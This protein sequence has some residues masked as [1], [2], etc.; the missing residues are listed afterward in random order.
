MI[1]ILL[2]S[3]F[4]ALLV[5]LA[6]LRDPAR[7]PRLSVLVLALLA[8]YPL[9]IFL[10][11]TSVV[12]VVPA[13]AVDDS[14]F[15]WVTVVLG[16]WVVGFSLA[17][18]R[19]LVAA[20]MIASWRKRSQ[21]V[22]EVDEVEIRQLAGL[23]GPVA[24]GVLR[25]VIFVPESW[26]LWSEEARKIVLAHELAHHLRRDPLWRWIAEIA[27]AVHGCNPLVVW[28]S[29]RMSL[30]GEYACDA[31]VLKNGVRPSDY[32]RLLCEFAEQ[33]APRGPVMAMAVASTL[34]SRVKR[35]MTPPRND[36]FAAL[37]VLV[38]LTLGLAGVLATFGLQTR[39]SAPVSAEEVEL[40][41]SANPFPGE[42]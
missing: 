27:C 21:L 14:G 36:G 31:L 9:T 12:V 8:L 34:E 37:M 11:K 41:W 18:I 35:M 10:P 32:V 22:G 28:I 2:F 19:L 17:V 38:P 1:A 26:S 3:G 24:A 20:R 16:L 30:Q 4:A 40:R 5:C 29:R 39:T 13:L 15:S 6:G 33:R 42:T 25:P 23:R 7:D